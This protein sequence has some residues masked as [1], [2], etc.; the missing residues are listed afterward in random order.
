MSLFLV[1]AIVLATGTAGAADWTNPQI[2]VS[3]DQLEQNLAKP[4][5]VVVDCRKLEDYAKGHIPGAISFGKECKKALRDGTSRV[6]KSTAKYDS[7]LSKAGIGNNS[8]VVFYGDMK[9]KSMD[10]ATIAFWIFEYL[11]HDKV[12][13]LNGGLE[14]WTKSKKLDTQPTIKPAAAFKAKPV[15]S[16]IATTEEVVQIAKGQVKGVQV[17][18]SRTKNEYAGDDIR[19]A[20]GG[21]IPNCTANVPHEST[22]D[23]VKDPA[24]GKDKSVGTL[25]AEKVAK[26]Y[27]DLDRNKRTIAYCQTGSRSTLTYME[28]RLLGFKNPAN[29]DD[30]WIIYG[31]TEKYPVEEEQ[32]I[33]LSRIKKLEDDLKKLQEQLKTQAGK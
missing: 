9:T 32:R 27:A 10:D 25:S 15:K 29:Y 33:D 30:S 19:A 13:V 21:R 7:M 6:F 16:R 11:G 2:L 31:A 12:H 17:I 24:S 22:Y 5:W 8:H 20:R 3:A 28:M 4:D 1:L 14:A 18:D 26:V 23:T